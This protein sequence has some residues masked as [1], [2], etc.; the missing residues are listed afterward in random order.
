MMFKKCTAVLLFLVLVA[1]S[2]AFALAAETSSELITPNRL[3]IRWQDG[4][5]AD[6]AIDTFRIRGFNVAQLRTLTQAVGGSVADAGNG[7]Y[8]ILLGGEKAP[9]APIS[10]EGEQTVRV[11]YNVTKIL[12]VTGRTTTPSEPGW[13]YLVDYM[14]NW[15][16]I[17]DVL[18]AMNL[19]IKSYLDEPGRGRTSVVIGEKAGFISGI[20]PS[21]YLDGSPFYAQY[22]AD[23]DRSLKSVKRVII[24]NDGMGEERLWIHF[25][26]GTSKA[27]IYKVDYEMQDDGSFVF[28]KGKTLKSFTLA[29]TDV[30]EYVTVVPEGIPVSA[31]GI[32]DSKGKEWDYLIGYNGRDGGVN[33]APVE[34]K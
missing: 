27:Y 2:S 24:F 4:R 25:P 26:Q 32:V 9:F 8:Q 6:T 31:L 13:V 3:T 5:E 17:R 23:I 34:L 30:L 10:F 11:Q 22:A 33:L 12:D 18:G 16:S 14:Y 7:A 15:G 20:P 28:I 1:A 19:E 29:S 21:G